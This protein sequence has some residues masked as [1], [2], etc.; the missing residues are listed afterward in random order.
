[1]HFCCKNLNLNAETHVFLLQKSGQPYKSGRPESGEQAGY[2]MKQAG[3][4]VITA[5][6]SAVVRRQ[7]SVLAAGALV[8]EA[9]VG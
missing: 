9:S 5:R 7:G 3:N 1:V 6:F 4:P 2:C 8:V